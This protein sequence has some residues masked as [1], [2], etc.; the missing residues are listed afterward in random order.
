MSAAGAGEIEILFEEVIN[1]FHKTLDEVQAQI[2]E[3]AD[4]LSDKM[5]YLPLPVVWAMRKAWDT[6]R[7]IASDIFDEIQKFLSEPGIPWALFRVGGYWDENIGVPVGS[8]QQA[9]SAFGKDADNRW[10][11]SAADA[12]QESADAQSRALTTIK[13]LTERI[14]NALR[15]M[16]WG[17][18]AFW[19]AL[20]AAMAAFAIGL[21]AALGLVASLVGAPAAPVDAGA[22]AA[23]VIGLVAAAAAAV[24][25]F[26]EKVNSTLESCDQVLRDNTGLVDNGNGSFGWP[27][28]KS[29]A[30]DGTGTWRPAG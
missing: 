20:A 22:T 10:D 29:M 1:E 14:D 8:I 5:R 28:L 17:L 24:V 16:A 19:T 11:G 13:P 15:D 9:A 21:A 27:R 26:A 3:L 7:E 18:I 6:F 23:V 12:Y 2:N 4:E 30:Y 25:A